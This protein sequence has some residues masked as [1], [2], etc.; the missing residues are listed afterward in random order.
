MSASVCEKIVWTTLRGNFIANVRRLLVWIPKASCWWVTA[1]CCTGNGYRTAWDNHQR[2]P[3][4]QKDHRYQHVH[5][6]PVSRTT[7]VYQPKLHTSLSL[8][9]ESRNW[10]LGQTKVIE[11]SLLVITMLKKKKI[12]NLGFNICKL[13]ATC[14]MTI[15]Y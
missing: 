5:P 11:F 8:T 10:S 14:K 15:M 2:P 13:S 4:R 3:Q 9:E 1:A 7:P 12:R 6:K